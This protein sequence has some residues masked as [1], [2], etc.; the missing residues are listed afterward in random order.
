MLFIGGGVATVLLLWENEYDHRLEGSRRATDNLPHHYEYVE[1]P[2]AGI[3]YYHYDS[4]APVDG[5]HDTD[6][7]LVWIAPGA[8]DDD[9][10]LNFDGKYLTSAV[11]MVDT[12]NTDLA[13]S[14]RADSV[15]VDFLQGYL[16]R[17][18]EVEHVNSF[19]LEVDESPAY[20]TDLIL[21]SDSAGSDDFNVKVLSI[22]LGD[23]VADVI[24]FTN[25]GDT[26]LSLVEA[27]AVPDTVEVLN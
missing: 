11:I 24:A 25:H 6:D 8:G 18:S 2:E 26:S 27:N 13:L 14:E 17:H 5:Y 4:W 7:Y 23:H 22:D 21:L 20:E 1:L 9:R 10:D 3:S 19:E 16:T 12:E 15:A